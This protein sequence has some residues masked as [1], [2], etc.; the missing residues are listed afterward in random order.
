VYEKRW[1]KRLGWRHESFYKIKETISGF[2]DETLNDMAD[3]GLKLPDEK[4]TVGGIFRAV[5]WN[6]PSL[7]IDA[8]KVFVS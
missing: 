8:A 4:R 1:H 2:S 5:L 3:V 7:L 6:K